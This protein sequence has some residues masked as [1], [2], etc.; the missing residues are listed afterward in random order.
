MALAVEAHFAQPAPVSAKAP[1][2][3]LGSMFI[4]EKLT[5]EGKINKFKLSLTIAELTF[6]SLA[7][8]DDDKIL[9][10]S[11]AESQGTMLKV[12]R[13]SFLQEYESTVNLKTFNVLRTTKHDVQKDRVRDSEAI[14]DYKERMVTYVETDPKDSNRPP[15][16][17]ASEITEPMYDM[18]SA[19][20]AIRKE[21]LSVGK[22]FNLTVSDSGLVFRV[23]VVITK[24][25]MQKTILGRVWCFRVEPEIFGKNRLI[26]QEGKM[27]IWMT[28][29]PRHIPVKAHID[30]EYGGVDIKL[31]S[32]I[33]PR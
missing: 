5:Y 15:R 9:I 18:I 11:E 10:K 29:D 8:P 32:A 25:E 3:T 24:R 12:F 2:K 28:D 6:T 21:A 33:T 7:H 19:V 1:A 30:T 16:R 20:Y 14:F 17:I 23:P 27:I 31:K 26:D 13:Y 22:K 4:G